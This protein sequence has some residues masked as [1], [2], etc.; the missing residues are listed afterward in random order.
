MS[1]QF[2]RWNF[3]GQ[4]VDRDYLEKVK[5][6]ITPYGPDDSGS[7][8]NTNI[9]I[10]YRAFHTTKESRREAQ[11]HLTPS[12]AV[13][14]WDGRLDNRAELI[15]LL[16]HV[17]TISSTDVAIVAAAYE[18]WGANC[19]PKL[20]GDWA[21]SIWNPNKRSLILAKDPIGTKHLYY[22]LDR[23]QITWSTILDP[24]VLFAGKTFSLCEE[25]I[26]GW[27]SFF[28]A[29]HLT[30]Y[31]GIH[32]VPAA[33][34]V[35]IRAGMHAVN[36]YWDFDRNK[37]ICY[38][39]DA[40]YEDHFR[41]VFAE[42]VRRRLRSD[43][44]ILAEL[45]GGMDSSSIV[46]MAD[47]LIADGVA[48]TLRLDTVSYYDDS[49]P[50]WD[51]RPYFTKVEKKRGRT[52]CHI[53]VSSEGSLLPKFVDTPFA[54]TPGS[55][56]RVSKAAT[57]FR[58]FILTQNY[59]AVLSGIGG[60]EVLGGVPTPTPELADYLLAASFRP[61]I[62]QMVAWA[63]A[64]RKPL[65]SLLSDVVTSFL[66]TTIAGIPRHKRPAPWLLRKFVGRNRV[67]LSA[68][69]TR[70][71]L[72]GSVPSFEVNMHT[73]A[74]LR[75]QL[76]SSSLPSCPTYEKRFP[77][78]DRDLL[79]FLYAVPRE[80]LV[81]PEQRRSLMRRA[82][83][84]IVPDEILHRKRKA[85]MSRCSSRTTSAEWNHLLEMTKRLVSS[86][87]GIVHTQEFSN[88]IQ[89]ARAAQE[90]APVS[91]VR[92]ISLEYW[93]RHLSHRGILKIDTA[94]PLQ[95]QFMT[96]TYGPS[97]EIESANNFVRKIFG[98]SSCHTAH[99]SS[100]GKEKRCSSRA[101]ER[102]SPRGLN[103]P[104]FED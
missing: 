104:T 46:C 34:S 41:T 91:L 30:P 67:A 65:L 10:L 20:I 29:A 5:P 90:T 35:L 62:H 56:P 28:P 23:N 6:I 61:L 98:P 4:S 52:G 88:A 32:S 8:S 38:R 72:I 94:N 48:Q 82:L 86:S 24:L 99:T 77:Y 57:E 63:L 31:V 85:F 27:L 53:D 92:T 16:G 70:L 73:L 103:V 40:E 37:R 7:Y 74:V 42:A 60:D 59:V 64:E 83:L 21:L 87:L 51:E 22:S 58:S 49:E 79:E 33:A 43:S 11:P 97:T 3:D 78:L 84:G 26:A 102:F 95:A 89:M 47:S 66:P 55:L 96:E 25:Y 93:L 100:Q 80:Q 45:S 1:V 71:K 13:I 68:C 50:N 14:T 17:L 101:E 69:N 76:T 36:K 15:R 9:S 2:G 39:T 75:T 81:R 19:F 44:P 12:G 54:A 18:D